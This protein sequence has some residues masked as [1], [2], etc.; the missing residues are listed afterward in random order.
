MSP[1]H[2]MRDKVCLS[3]GVEA[4]DEL[5]KMEI[6]EVGLVWL[7]F[8]LIIKSGIVGFVCGVDWRT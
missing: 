5:E 4:K 8:R 6:L 2:Q 1:R 3:C 7:N